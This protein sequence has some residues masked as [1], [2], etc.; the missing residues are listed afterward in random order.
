VVSI[1][2]ARTRLRKIGFFMM[3]PKVLVYTNVN[4]LRAASSLMDILLPIFKGNCRFP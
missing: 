4:T 3:S 2:V 1:V